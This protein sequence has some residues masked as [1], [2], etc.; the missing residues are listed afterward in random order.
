M[1]VDSGAIIAE[2]APAPTS[3]S[4]SDAARE[5][6]TASLSAQ[7]AQKK[8]KTGNGQITQFF[9]TNSTSNVEC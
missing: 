6:D 4:P 9:R 5:T 8:R 1:E 2:N 7:T 3:A